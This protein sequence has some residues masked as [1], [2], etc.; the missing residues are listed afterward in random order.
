MPN[1]VSGAADEPLACGI[2]SLVL[3]EALQHGFSVAPLVDAVLRAS[4]QAAP[5]TS[6]SLLPAHKG[7]ASGRPTLGVVLSST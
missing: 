1:G 4:L 7:C 6:C 2:G 5:Q 3:F